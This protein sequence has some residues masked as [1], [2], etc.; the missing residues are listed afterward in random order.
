MNNITYI[1]SGCGKIDTETMQGHIDGNEHVIFYYDY[2]Y[3][4]ADDDVYDEETCGTVTISLVDTF[5][6]IIK[7][8]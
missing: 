3:D 4:E 6:N 5:D 8:K 2:G 1:C 7:S